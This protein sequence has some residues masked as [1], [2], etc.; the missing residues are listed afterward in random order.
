ML[1][2]FVAAKQ[3]ARALGR[4]LVRRVGVNDNGVAAVESVS[5]YTM[6]VVFSLTALKFVNVPLTLF[7]FLGGAIAIGVGFGSQKILNNFISGLILLA[8][9]PIRVGD[10]IQMNDLYGTVEH[11]GTRSTRIR[12]ATNMEIIVPNSTFLENNV[13]NLTLGDYKIR[14]CV[15]VGVCYGSPTREVARLLK[16]AAQEHGVVLKKPEP[17]VWFVEFGDNSLN[18]ELHFWVE[19]R[20]VT[21]RKRIESDLRFKINE[22]FREAGIIIAYPQRDIHFDTARP[23]DVN[24]HMP[25]ADE[26]TSAADQAKAA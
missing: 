3:L 21:E 12:T 18:F 17:F 10:L 9:R 7:T 13:L 2:G 14:A 25:D 4:R 20:N 24:V 5:F 26:P 11:I 19:V 22:L 1:V 16:R 8:E 15:T 23:I 6:L